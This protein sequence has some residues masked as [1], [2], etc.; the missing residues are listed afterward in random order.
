MLSSLPDRPLTIAEATA[1]DASTGIDRCKPVIGLRRND[2]T[3]SVVVV[4]LGVDDAIHLLGYESAA[5]GWERLDSFSTADPPAR[6]D[7]AIEHVLEWAVTYYGVDELTVMAAPTPDADAVVSWFPPRPV[8]PHEVFGLEVLIGVVAV[9]PAFCLEATHEVVAVLVATEEARDPAAAWFYA[10]GYDE[11]ASAWTV[12]A[13]ERVGPDDEPELA[14]AE[15]L[16][17]WVHDRYASEELI[18]I[19]PP[20]P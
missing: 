11:D 7:T 13:D 14:L 17:D 20:E 15:A 10:V 1:L 19:A 12:V 18:A 4:Y 16:F 9:H 5:G 6:F 8:C 3:A 2:A